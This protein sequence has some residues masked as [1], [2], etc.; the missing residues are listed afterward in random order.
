MEISNHFVGMEISNDF[1]GME[2]I[3][4]EQMENAIELK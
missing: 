4:W 2:E 3:K 1:L